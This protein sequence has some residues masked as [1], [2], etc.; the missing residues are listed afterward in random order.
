MFNWRLL[1]TQFAN[2]PLCCLYFHIKSKRRCIWSFLQ[3]ETRLQSCACVERC[4]FVRALRCRQTHVRQQPFFA[5]NLRCGSALIFVCVLR[6]F[7][8]WRSID[9]NSYFDW[10]IR[11]Y[12]WINWVPLGTSPG[13]G[14]ISPEPRCLK[15]R[16]WKQWIFKTITEFPSI[17]EGDN[18]NFALLFSWTI[19]YAF[20]DFINASRLS[21]TTELA[22]WS[23]PHE[24]NF[25]LVGCIIMM[26]CIYNHTMF[27]LA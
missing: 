24:N 18:I 4:I 9:R 1:I 7:F 5:K 27:K 11:F 6:W 13:E 3:R 20:F 22:F 16:H 23:W 2:A 17:N 25:L 10:M 8:W 15:F 21:I 12:G 19:S 14:G 26:I